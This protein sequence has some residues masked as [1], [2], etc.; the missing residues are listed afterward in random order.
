MIFPDF[1]RILNLSFWFRR[2]FGFAD[3]TKRLSD[4]QNGQA[5]FLA[6]LLGDS[7]GFLLE[8]NSFFTNNSSGFVDV[9]AVLHHAR[10]ELLGIVPE[11]K[12]GVK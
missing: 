11:K 3:Y 9:L 6:N 2:I 8:Y 4:L 1:C 10:T 7:I 5:T 12:G